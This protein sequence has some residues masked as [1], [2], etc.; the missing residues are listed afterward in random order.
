MKNLFA[1]LY[2]PTLTI[3]FVVTIFLSA[4]GI[5]LVDVENQKALALPILIYELFLLF[6]MLGLRI[7]RH[8]YISKMNKKQGGK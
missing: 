6:L 2:W 7:A 4:V 3:S 1:K 8:L 5:F